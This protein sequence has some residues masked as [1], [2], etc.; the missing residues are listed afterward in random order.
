M[1]YDKEFIE[2]KERIANEPHPI[3]KEIIFWALF[4]ILMKEDNNVPMHSFLSED[5]LKE[6]KEMIPMYSE[7]EEAR[8]NIHDDNNIIDDY[9]SIKAGETKLY[10]RNTHTDTSKKRVFGDK[11]EEYYLDN[12]LRKQ[13]VIK[14]HNRTY[15]DDG[16]YIINSVWDANYIDNVLHG[17]S[18]SFSRYNNAT[19]IEEYDMGK[20]VDTKILYQGKEFVEK[21]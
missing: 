5:N 14:E 4:D 15:S 1:K 3:K 10:T 19:V 13:G 17:T 11:Y 21:K 18:K 8:M 2:T 20:V 16:V 6:F 7:Y 9:L 12:Q